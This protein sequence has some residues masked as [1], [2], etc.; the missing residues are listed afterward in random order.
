MSFN[1]VISRHLLLC[2]LNLAP[3]PKAITLTYF[4]NYKT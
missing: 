3:K 1:M 2:Q 4:Y